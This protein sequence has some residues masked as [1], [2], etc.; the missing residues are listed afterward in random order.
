MMR[1]LL[2]G[3]VLGL[4]IGGASYLHFRRPKPPAEVAYAASRQVTIWSTTAQVRELVTTVSFGERLD[5]LDRSGDQVQ[6]RTV[7]GLTGWASDRDLLSAE[8]WGKAQEIDAATSTLPIE[9]RGRTRVLSNL[10]I[11][12]GR[13]SPRIRQ[14][15]KGVSVDLFERRPLDMPPSASPNSG[16]DEAS[17]STAAVPRK[18]DWWLVRAHVDAQTKVG[19]WM[20]GRFI[21]L[22]VPAPLPDYVSAAGMR[23]V[24]WF[25][26]NKVMDAT[27]EPKPQY[28]VVGDRGPEGQP[29]D[30]TQLRVYTWS[31]VRERYETA[32]VASAFCG[33]LPVNVTHAGT[34]GEDER[35]SFA[36]LGGGSSERIY[37]MRQNIVRR[38]SDGDPGPAASRRRH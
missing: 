5:V 15:N 2:I 30:F 11:D 31:K 12:P 37:R 4:A 17:A 16:D 6:V 25:E 20:L 33:K 36:E 18:E 14:L 9:A 22:D 28:L 13:E 29:C 19:G 1:K 34:R 35:F 24:A 38:V 8:L 32:F 21:D 3:F 27:G 26:L 23:I 7:A 10:H